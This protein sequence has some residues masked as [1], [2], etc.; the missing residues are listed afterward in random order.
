MG[1]IPVN[2]ET[3]VEIVSKTL[4][5]VDEPILK[6]AFGWDLQK[7]TPP[8]PEVIPFTTYFEFNLAVER[9][10]KDMNIEKM[11]QDSIARALGAV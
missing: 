2:P 8:T 7:T 6:K 4:G 1:T 3:V 5:K 11:A 10:L 9:R